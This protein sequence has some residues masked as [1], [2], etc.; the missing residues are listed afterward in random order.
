MRATE[1]I[2]CGALDVALNPKHFTE[3]KLFFLASVTIGM[4]ILALE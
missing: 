4:T 1:A 2:V 3:I